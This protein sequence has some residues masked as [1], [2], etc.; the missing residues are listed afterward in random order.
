MG[1]W[2]GKNAAS[3]TTS[4]WTTIEPLMVEE[5]SSFLPCGW[6]LH[7]PWTSVA[8]MLISIIHTYTWL[9]RWT[10]YFV[11]CACGGKDCCA[12]AGAETSFNFHPVPH[13]RWTVNVS[14]VTQRLWTAFFGKPSQKEAF[15]RYILGKK[16]KSVGQAHHAISAQTP[17][18]KLHYFLGSVKYC[19]FHAFLAINPKYQR[20]SR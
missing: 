10:T 18:Q 1:A 13:N 8:R 7:G 19:V 14:A 12:C 6:R 16:N 4:S 17:A 9:K 15:K 2:S 5:L 3:C 20:K 11:V